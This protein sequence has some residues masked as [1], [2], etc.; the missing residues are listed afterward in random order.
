VPAAKPGAGIG[1]A[2]GGGEAAGVGAAAGE[3]AGAMGGLAEGLG[4]VAAM[5]GP[6]GAAI[7]AVVMVGGAI[8]DM[9]KKVM[10]MSLEFGAKANPAVIERYNLA[11]DDQ[12]AVIGHRLIPVVELMTDAYRLLGDLLA[13]ILPDTNDMRQA[14]SP[15]KDGLKDMRNVAERLAPGLRAAIAAM[16]EMAAAAAKIAAAPIKYGMAGLAIASGNPTAAA[17]A[18]AGVG[19][20]GEPLKSSVGASAQPAQFM[21]IGAYQRQMYERAA[22]MGKP[23]EKAIAKSKIKEGKS[24][25]VLD[26]MFDLLKAGAIPVG[27]DK[28]N[29]GPLETKKVGDR[30]RPEIPFADGG[31]R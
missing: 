9:V 11:V 18:G 24:D 20:G 12:Q 31:G 23:D 15:L 13:S 21:D 3:A 6:V 4:A 29:A 27:V 17:I 28:W 1:A 14:L 26:K 16:L 8:V 5:A 7:G 19:A 10:S 25:Y 2:A 30:E 22:S